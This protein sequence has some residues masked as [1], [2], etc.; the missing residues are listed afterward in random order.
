MNYPLA[1]H[2]DPERYRAALRA[3]LAKVRAFAPVYL[4]VCLGLDTAKGDPTG[5]WSNRG[6]D[7]ERMG[8]AIGAVR[9][10]TLVVQ[11]GGYENRS[12]GANAA[13]FFEGLA[14]GLGLG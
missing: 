11:E 12:I 14:R 8:E 6:V 3:A 5:S 4:V 9:L 7:F 10:P 13:R 1:E 2:A